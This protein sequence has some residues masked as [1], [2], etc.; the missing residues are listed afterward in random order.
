VAGLDAS[1]ERQLEAELI[2]VEPQASILIANEDRDRVNPEIGL[3]RDGV[4]Q[5][6]IIG[7]C[8]VSF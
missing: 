7:P 8:P 2:H 4:G 3:E 6:R 1:V 5:G